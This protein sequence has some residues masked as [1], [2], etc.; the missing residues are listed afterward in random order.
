MNIKPLIVE[1]VRG[2]VTSGKL[3]PKDFQFTVEVE[4]E[5]WDVYRVDAPSGMPGVDGQLAFR[6]EDGLAIIGWFGPGSYS[7]EEIVKY[8]GPARMGDPGCVRLVEVI[9]RYAR[10][11]TVSSRSSTS[12]SW[13]S[14]SRARW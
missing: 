13:R 7:K 1:A 10:R 4:G 14:H 6:L 9:E 2:Y 11:G 8:I 12:A 5:V 3:T